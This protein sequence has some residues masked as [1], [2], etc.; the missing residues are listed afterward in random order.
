MRE[1]E[2]TTH[3]LIPSNSSFSRRSFDDEKPSGS[4]PSLPVGREF[5]AKVFAPILGVM[6][7]KAT[8]L[9][10]TCFRTVDKEIVKQLAERPVV[11]F[12]ASQGGASQAGVRVGG[13][14]NER[15]RHSVCHKTNSSLPS[16]LRSSQTC[17]R[18]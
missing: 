6:F 13:K 11:A 8:E 1:R 9:T 3:A 2:I 10:T 15:M 5:E 4:A 17:A 14:K 18:R 16:S 7:Y 12:V